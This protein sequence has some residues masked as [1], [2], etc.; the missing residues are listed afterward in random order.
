MITALKRD[1]MRYQ[2]N[3]LKIYLALI[4]W[5]FWVALVHYAWLS[6]WYLIP[7]TGMVLSP[8]LVWVL[9][10]VVREAYDQT[11]EGIKQFYELLAAQIGCGL[12]LSSAIQETVDTMKRGNS[13]C[14][15]LTE[16]LEQLVIEIEIG[17]F[18]DESLKPL[19]NLSQVEVLIRG[20]EMIG[21]CMRTGI[22][23]ESLLIQFSDMLSELLKYKRDFANRLS[24]KR[25][26]FQIMMLSCPWWLL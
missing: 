22:G 9:R 24:Q 12:A 1:L 2:P 19:A 20:T 17:L 10:H 15:A 18:N 21:I 26:E 16:P 14:S 25:G 5:I 3:R 13:I 7:V 11:I 8:N 23:M 6:K 4:F